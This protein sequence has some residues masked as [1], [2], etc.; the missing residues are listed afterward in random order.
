MSLIRCVLWILCASV[1]VSV[2]A[3][4]Y[5]TVSETVSA[6][7]VSEDK[8]ISKAL[9]QAVQ[10]ANGAAI[11]VESHIR[12][13]EQGIVVDWM[14]NQTL[15]PAREVNTGYTST[16]AGGLV[17][18]YRVIKSQYNN[19]A[20]VWEVKITAEVAK[21]ANIGVD[22][23]GLL[24]IAVLPFRTTDASFASVN[25]DVDA[26]NVSQR[27]NEL[28]TNAMVDSGKYRV[29][30]RSFWQESD[31]EEVIV[32]ERSYANQE[33]IKLG[34]KLGADYMVVGSINDFDIARAIKKIYGAS[35]PVF[36]TR[37]A[38]QLRVIE[39]ATSD[40]IVSTH[41]TETFDPRQ[42]NT[43]LN[44]LRSASPQ[45]SEAQ[46]TTDLESFIYEKVSKTLVDDVIARISGD[47]RQTEVL[48]APETRE[49]RPLTPGS[50]EKPIEWH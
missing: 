18:S 50:S 32:R 37:I 20:K 42:L 36:E 4:S 13:T 30:D 6:T 40:I 49:A 22:R 8:A 17:K 46:L 33:S 24:Q 38:I 10:Q 39:V 35:T 12:D 11:K 47:P 15:I 41:F 21:Y 16:T 43:R 9:A 2:F 3:A 48:P 31:V 5:A 45:K 27:V 44:Q 23:S 19:A 14:G 7:G 25:G 28:M 29:L 1:S 26:A 34:Q